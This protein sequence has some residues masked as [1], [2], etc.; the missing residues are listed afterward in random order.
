[1]VGLE[2]QIIEESPRLADGPIHMIE[3]RCLIC[4]EGFFVGFCSAEHIAWGVFTCEPCRRKKRIEHTLRR[5]NAG[6]SLGRLN[7]RLLALR[8]RL[9]DE[10]VALDEL[11]L[12]KE[13]NSAHA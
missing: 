10:C 13:R 12:Q 7:D 5:L 11:E 3:N 4:G 9:I 6:L 8:E 2:L 1:M